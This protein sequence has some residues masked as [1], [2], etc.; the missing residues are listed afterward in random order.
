MIVF[1]IIG[2]LKTR[3][4]KDQDLILDIASAEAIMRQ[5]PDKNGKFAGSEDARLAL[6]SFH[7]ILQRFK[8]QTTD[9]VELDKLL[10]EEE[11]LFRNSRDI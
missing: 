5:N 9:P 6:A 2:D 3:A 11:A 4:G 7:K 8:Q 1:G 10:K